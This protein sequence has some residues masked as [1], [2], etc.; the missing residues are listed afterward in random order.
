[1][2]ID[3]R[4]LGVRAGTPGA[5]RFRGAVRILLPAL[6]LAQA[7]SAASLFG[8][9]PS[10]TLDY[11]QFNVYSMIG[12]SKNP[13]LGWVNSTMGFE[14]SLPAGTYQL[15]SFTLALRDPVGNVQATFTLYSGDTR[16]QT[17]L[18]SVTES[19]PGSSSFSLFN[20]AF[21]GSL[22]L[23]GLQNYFLIGSVPQ[24]TSGFE[25]I[26]WAASSPGSAVP[27]F[28]GQTWL[29]GQFSSNGFLGWNSFTPNPGPAWQLSVDAAAAPEPAPV[30]ML[31][32]GLG[33]VGIGVLRRRS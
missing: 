9:D 25:Q 13:S 26:D 1:M 20:V 4:A 29:T 32:T 8:T 14:F 27:V 30:V 23:S 7:L 16:P 28:Y 21:P 5:G 12:D 24:V 17:A 18:A 6:A 22:T 33:L 10:G 31:L 2:Q 11:N 19:L 15:D 3:F